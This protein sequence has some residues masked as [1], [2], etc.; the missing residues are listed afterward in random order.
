MKTVLLSSALL[1]SQL[2]I[3]PSFLFRD[4]E[5]LVTEVAFKSSLMFPAF[6]FLIFVTCL[7][8]E[9]LGVVGHIRKLQE[10]YSV[11]WGA[12][13]PGHCEHVQLNR[14]QAPGTCGAPARS[15]LRLH[16]SWRAQ[17]TSDL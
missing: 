12:Y 1:E 10:A 14:E 17:L 5:K 16:N 15:G 3:S 9:Q 7:S 6:A 4:G 8:N 11:L 13:P 2:Q